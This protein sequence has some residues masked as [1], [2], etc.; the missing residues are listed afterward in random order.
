M[1]FTI[2]LLSAASDR[3]KIFHPDKPFY[4]FRSPTKFVHVSA[5]RSKVSRGADR[6]AFHHSRHSI[7]FSQW[8]NHALLASRETGS[9]CF[10]RARHT[11]SNQIN[12]NSHFPMGTSP[13]MAGRASESKPLA[14]AAYPP[15]AG[16]LGRMDRMFEIGI[17]FS[18]SDTL[19]FQGESRFSHAS[20]GL[21]HP[22][23]SRR[24][25]TWTKSKRADDE[26][27]VPAYLVTFSIY[28][29][30]N[31]KM[32]PRFCYGTVLQP[33]S[34]QELQSTREHSLF[35]QH[36]TRFPVFSMRRSISMARSWFTI[37]ALRRGLNL[38]MPRQTYVLP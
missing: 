38:E 13:L 1:V 4:V 32:A 12:Q 7:V 8:Y 29:G 26:N 31:G 14:M 6:R 17:A 2:A 18:L 25:L 34:W 10:N 24:H 11:K 27:H 35:W 16:T 5:D 37:L 9:P 19:L 30:S 28:L 3:F 21:S 33:M 23:T 15:L 36:A 22:P 20:R